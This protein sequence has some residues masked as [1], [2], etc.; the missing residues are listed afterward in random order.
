MSGNANTNTV[1]KFPPIV[2][3]TLTQDLPETRCRRNHVICTIVTN[4][5]KQPVELVEGMAMLG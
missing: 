1:F 4:V 3:V 2:V 5:L